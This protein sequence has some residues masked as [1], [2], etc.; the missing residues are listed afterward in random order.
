MQR[1]DSGH[2]DARKDTR[3][4][5]FVPD[6]GVADETD[7]SSDLWQMVLRECDKV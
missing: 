7:R 3:G 2:Q 6:Q 4:R 1:V 5:Q